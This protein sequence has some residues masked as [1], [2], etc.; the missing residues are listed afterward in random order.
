MYYTPFCFSDSSLIACGI[1]YNG[2]T[3][4]DGAIIY[5]WDKLVNIYV[6]ILETSS[7]P[8]EMM[9]LWNHQIHLWL[10][11]Y[12]TLRLVGPG[13]SVGFKENMITFMVSAIW[14]GFYPFYYIMFAQCAV[15]VQV[16]KEIYRSRIIF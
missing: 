10:K 14:H 7:S 11:N 1:S 12:V 6:W 8:V 5:K 15:F 9:K 13:K 16:A 4:K 3:K 2:F